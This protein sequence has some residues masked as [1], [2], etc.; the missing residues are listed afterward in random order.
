VRSDKAGVYEPLQDF[1]QEAL[2]DTG[3]GTNN[4]ELGLLA[5]GK[6][7]EMDDDANGIVCGAS[8]LHAELDC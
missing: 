3:G 4:G 8:N 7:R 5:F 2:A 6:S 1:R